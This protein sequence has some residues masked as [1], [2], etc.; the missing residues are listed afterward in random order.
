M[1]EVR[2]FKERTVITS[3]DNRD[4]AGGFLGC[5]IPGHGQ[6]SSQKFSEQGR[7]FWFQYEPPADTE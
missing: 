1:L 7:L 3:P 4:A 5:R 6:P 2:V